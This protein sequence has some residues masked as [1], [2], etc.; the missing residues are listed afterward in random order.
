MVW[1]AKARTYFIEKAPGA[2]EGKDF[3]KAWTTR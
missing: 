1:M 2:V 3:L